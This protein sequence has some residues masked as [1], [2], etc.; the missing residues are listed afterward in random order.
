MWKLA[1]LPIFLT[2]ALAVCQDYT[3]VATSHTN[4]T[5]YEVEPMS[6]KILHTFDAA[7]GPNGAK[8]DG[9]TVGDAQVPID[10][11]LNE[12][13]EGAISPD[14][15]SV[16]ISVPYASQ[17]LILD[18]ASFK[19]K[20]VIRSEY[21][22]RPAET[23]SFAR[24]IKKVTTSADPHG[25]ALNADASKLYITLEYAVVPGIAVYDVKSKKVIK[26]IDTVVQETIFRFNPVRINCTSRQR[27]TWSW[28]S[29]RRVTISSRR[30]RLR[31]ILTAWTS[32]PMEKCGLIRTPVGQLP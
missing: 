13:H 32:L 23:R 31:V 4:A 1:G 6:G 19:E 28:W 3:I 5:V 12:V 29:T 14:G 18:G 30:F 26:K 17:V 27:A 11:W 8:G 25:L 21:F 9:S 16:Y 7:T 10:V 2:S 24:K 22:K 20:G 15:K